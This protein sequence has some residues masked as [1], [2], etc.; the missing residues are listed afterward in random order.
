MASQRSLVDTWRHLEAALQSACCRSVSPS[1]FVLQCGHTVCGRCIQKC[2]GSSVEYL[3]CPLCKELTL[4]GR[5]VS[6]PGLDKLTS[7]LFYDPRPVRTSIVALL[8]EEDRQRAFKALADGGG[9]GVGAVFSSS[10]SSSRGPT[11][12]PLPLAAAG[13]NNQTATTAARAAGAVAIHPDQHYNASQPT[14]PYPPHSSHDLAVPQ[15]R[16]VAPSGFPRSPP[17]FSGFPRG[18]AEVG[19]GGAAVTAPAYPLPLHSA[20]AQGHPGEFPSGHQPPPTSLDIPPQ[21]P[22]FGIPP[23][24]HPEGF[25]PAHPLQHQDQLR[26]QIQ[27]QQPSPPPFHH[28][29]QQQATLPSHSLHHATASRRELM[30]SHPT[31]APAPATEPSPGVPPS[32]QLP[33]QLTQT[34][35]PFSHSQPHQEVT[36][37]APASAGRDAFVSWQQG[38][39]PGSAA[40]RDRVCG[41]PGSN[42][43]VCALPDWANEDDV[44]ARARQFGRVLGCRVLRHSNGRSRGLAYLAMQSPKEAYAVIV[45][46]WEKEM[47]MDENDRRFNPAKPPKTRISFFDPCKAEIFELLSTLTD[48]EALPLK[49]I[50][51]IRLKAKQELQQ[52]QQQQGNTATNTETS[53]LGCPPVG[54]FRCGGGDPCGAPQAQCSVLFTEGEQESG[55]TSGEHVRQLLVFAGVS[56]GLARALFPSFSCATAAL[57]I[58]L[59][60]EEADGLRRH[61]PTASLLLTSGKPKEEGDLREEEKLRRAAQDA[62]RRLPPLQ[63]CCCTLSPTVYSAVAEALIRSGRKEAA[64]CLSDYLGTQQDLW[65]GVESGRPRELKEAAA[66]LIQRMFLEANPSSS[67]SSSGK[68]GIEAASSFLWVPVGEALR[69]WGAR[70]RAPVEEKERLMVGLEKGTSKEALKRELRKLQAAGRSGRGEGMGRD[71]S[72]GRREEN[73][74]TG[75]SSTAQHTTAQQ[76]RAK[77]DWTLG[78]SKKERDGSE[79]KDG[80]MDRLAGYV[81]AGKK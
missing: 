16:E 76:R 65:E 8:Q 52:E 31:P 39:Q 40:N 72:G 68:G 44:C 36:A 18:Q 56:V 26:Q 30:Q 75:R 3:I 69:D 17:G 33:P 12:H 4:S 70:V 79:G 23:H 42:I 27:T 54:K 49:R 48:N 35:P 29:Q 78:G 46:L 77:G 64:L 43:F 38:H 1:H 37:A 6:V 22:P 13:L 53:R 10:S 28:H 32:H 71:R 55:S 11:S 20:S 2:T 81:D 15:Q 80:W 61:S 41:P 45:G 62:V 9:G 66:C 60:L 50:L 58:L 5:Q 7:I 34:S 47:K 51:D 25:P 74:G 14:Y 73:K 57:E 63:N 67:S 59:L 24:P 21:P 19:V